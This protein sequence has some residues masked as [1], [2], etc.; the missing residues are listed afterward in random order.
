MVLGYGLDDKEFESQQ[1][2]E[3]FLFTTVS[4]PASGPHRDDHLPQSSAKVKN[5][6]RYTSIPPIRFHDVLS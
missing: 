3:I 5:A 6:R 1:G 4:R 2:L